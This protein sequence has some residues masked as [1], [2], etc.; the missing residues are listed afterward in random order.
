[1]F[2]KIALSNQ[3]KCKTLNTQLNTVNAKSVST[4]N[5]KNKIPKKIETN[6][7]IINPFYK[8]MIIG[9]HN[10]MDADMNADADADMDADMDA[11][12]DADMD[13]D[14]D[15]DADADADMDA[16]ADVYDEDYFEKNEYNH[17]NMELRTNSIPKN[18]IIKPNISIIS[19][20]YITPS[21]ETCYFNN[22]ISSMNHSTNSTTIHNL[23]DN[24]NS[25]INVNFKTSTPWVEKYRPSNFEDIV[26]I[27]NY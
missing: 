21:M 16:D 7:K 25:T 1:M 26:L 18:I 22:E 17:K 6:S 11:D 4:T 24:N 14:M 8:K 13:V 12:A 15:V 9:N 27:N 20:S 10:N 5:S 3:K 19:E 2:T 23:L